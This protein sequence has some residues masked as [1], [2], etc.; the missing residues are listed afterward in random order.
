[1]GFGSQN[2]D[3]GF[4]ELVSGFLEGVTKVLTSLVAVSW[5][6]W[7]SGGQF[8]LVVPSSENNALVADDNASAGG[9]AGLEIADLGVFVPS[10]GHVLIF[11]KSQAG[12]G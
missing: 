10:D 12:L 11:V 3:E 2:E 4:K 8:Q 1:M 7:F 6:L 9:L 5:V